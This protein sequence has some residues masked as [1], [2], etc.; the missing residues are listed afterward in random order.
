MTKNGTTSGRRRPWMRPSG[1]Y[2]IPIV[3]RRRATVRYEAIGGVPG[4][5]VTGEPPQKGEFDHTYVE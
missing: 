2:S 3:P 1:S 4:R 5:G